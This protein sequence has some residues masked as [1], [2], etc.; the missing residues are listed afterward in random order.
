MGQSEYLATLVAS[1]LISV[2]LAVFFYRRRPAPGAVTMAVLFGLV[3]IWSGGY[4]AE[5]VSG[6]IEVHELAT[7]IE[8]F[9]FAGLPAMWF[10]F[11][12]RYARYE[13]WLTRRPYLLAIIPL[14][15]LL[16]VWTNDMHGWVW[17]DARLQQF[18][19][20][21]IMT[22]TYGIW[23]WGH[24]VYSYALA[25][26]GIIVIAMSLF[27]PRKLYRNQVIVLLIGV[28]LPLIWNIIF[29]FRAPPTYYIDMA[30]LAFVASGIVLAVGLFRFRILEVVPIARG[31]IVDNMSDGVIVFDRQNRILDINPAAEKI[32]GNCAAE[33]IGKTAGVSLANVPKLLNQVSND[34]STPVAIDIEGGEAPGCYESDLEPLFDRRRHLI[35][36]VITLHNLTERKM[37][38]QSLKEYAR[39][40]TQVQEEERKRIA[41]ELHDDTAQYLSIL[42]MQLGALAQSG[43]IQS[44]EVLEKLRLLEKDADRAYQDIR[45]YSHELRP[46]VLEHLGLPVALEQMVEDTN[47]L[48][49]LSVDLEVAG[50]DP[51][52]PEDVKLGFFR[53]AQEAVNNARKHS[54][55]SRVC[56][57]LQYTGERLRMS[58]IDN[59]TGFDIHEASIRAVKRGSLGLMSMQER[60]RLI[61]ADLKIDSA[62][63]KGTTV[64]VEI[65]S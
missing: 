16:L 31:T 32:I 63:G 58:V 59:G 42:K 44:R 28:V 39:R 9:C 11:T 54:G 14:V 3:F 2:A 49:Q 62:P 8:Y 35:G 19:E 48:D 30:P 57:R 25:L 34:G 45:R 7:R 53:V 38:E 47:R 64:T 21:T 12:T 43:N 6:S 52:L 23:F 5:A 4:I 56:I 1:I 27:H 18:G 15:T 65:C 13:N 61:G 29:V 51:G 24:A 26:W 37:M 33:L 46:G 40:I 36:R 22:K 55:A 50:E 10:I 41:Y 60:A 17:Y 20:F